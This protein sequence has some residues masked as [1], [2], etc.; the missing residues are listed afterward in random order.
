LV[1]ARTDGVVIV[2]VTV[3]NVSRRTE[4]IS[5]FTLID[6]RGGAFNQA[7]AHM[8]EVA[9]QNATAFIQGRRF[10]MSPIHTKAGDDASFMN[11]AGCG[12]R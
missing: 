12:Q 2:F 6:V 1:S 8:D 3:I 10:G 4:L 9:Q 5:R 11:E 7:E